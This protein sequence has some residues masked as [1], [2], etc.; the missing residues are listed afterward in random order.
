MRLKTAIITLI[1]VLTTSFAFA[2]NTLGLLDNGDGTWNVEYVSDGN[3][4]GFQFDVDGATIKQTS[5]FSMLFFNAAVWSMIPDSKVRIVRRIYLRVLRTI[6]ANDHTATPQTIGDIDVLVHTGQPDV[7]I[8][9]RLSRLRY[10][11]RLINYAPP[12]L[13]G[14]LQAKSNWYS[15]SK[16]AREACSLTSASA[17]SSSA[18]TS[19]WPSIRP[20]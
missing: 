19:A 4:A 9:V 5:T 12:P 17:C 11:P 20:Q 1:T 18:A 2:N 8:G 10:L 14:L 3:I 15:R 6:A 16:L 13:L 7:L